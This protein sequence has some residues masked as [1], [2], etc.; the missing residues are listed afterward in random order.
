VRA[1]GD[2]TRTSGLRGRRGHSAADRRITLVLLV[3]A[4]TGACTGSGGER[5]AA[6]SATSHAT[7]GPSSTARPS[8]TA[9][10]SSTAG[11]SSTAGGSSTARP[12]STAGPSGSPEPSTASSP[13]ADSDEARRQGVVEL[14]RRRA[15]ALRSGDRQAWLA[16]VSDPA[17]PFAQR[18]GA[19]F[20]RMRLLPITDFDQHGVEVA[21]APSAARE[22][23][24]GAD[25]WVSTVHLTYRLDGYDRAPRSFDASF[26]VV[27]TP[28]GWRLADDT[29]GRTQP[30]PWDIPSMAVVRSPTTLVIGSAPAATLRDYLALAEAAHTRIAGIWGSALSGVIVAP[31]TVEQ[32]AAQLQRPD[33]LGLEQVAA[34]T[35]GPIGPGSP[36]TTDRVYVNPQAFARL[37]PDGRRV[38]LTH[39]LTHVTVRGTTDRPVPLWLSE[40]F[41]DYVGFTGLSLTPRTVAAD[42]LVRVRAGTGPTRLPVPDDFDPRKGIIAPTY[43]A[44]WL[45]VT[46]MAQVHGGD[47][48]VAFYRAVGGLAVDPTTAGDPAAVTGQAFRTVL[49]TSEEAFVADWLAYLEQLAR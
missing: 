8:N 28:D 37:T 26:T 25:A 20:D 40:G 15:L 44:A 2:T 1:R 48:V 23:A 11:P 5:Q 13:T 45:A 33:A 6:A 29:D 30:Q 34:I 38:V 43:S 47:R 21:P 19:V 41:A 24:V 39:E 22:A 27:S 36:A 9:G 10:G 31:A 14:I 16:T 4:S 42:L 12:S 7:S 46:R 3:A 18:Q 17:S 49:G 35:D 32:L